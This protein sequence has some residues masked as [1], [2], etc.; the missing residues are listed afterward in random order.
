MI[1][2]TFGN[3]Y[4]VSKAYVLAGFGEGIIEDWLMF[5]RMI[6]NK[7]KTVSK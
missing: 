5:F 6:D 2:D 3:R 1:N 7:S 4:K